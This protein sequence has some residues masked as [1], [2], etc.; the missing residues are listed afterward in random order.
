MVWNGPVPGPAPGPTAHAGPRSSAFHPPCD[1]GISV[2]RSSNPDAFARGNV[3]QHYGTAESLSSTGTQ[4]FPLRLLPLPSVVKLCRFSW[5][6]GLEEA[7]RLLIWITT[8]ERPVRDPVVEEEHRRSPAAA[9]PAAGAEASAGPGANAPWG[10]FRRNRK[11]GH[12]P[13]VWGAHP[14]LTRAYRPAWS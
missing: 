3:L 11:I 12:A 1:G 10:S 7:P 13:I 14:H 6:S 2:P 5:S 8:P 9:T 4:R